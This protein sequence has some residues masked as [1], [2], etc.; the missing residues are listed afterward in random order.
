MCSWKDIEG[1]LGHYQ[2]SDSGLVRS[3][4]S[5]DSKILSPY[6]NPY[7]YLKI[8][9]WLNNKQRHHFIH[10]LVLEAFNPVEGMENLEV[11]HRNFI[12]TDNDL[13]NL[14]WVTHAQNM[15]HAEKNGAAGGYRGRTWRF[16]L[17]DGSI[18][19]STGIK[20]FCDKYGLSYASMYNVSSGRNKSHKGFSCLL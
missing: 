16:V 10:R 1:Y 9:L 19:E 12:K 14:E 13:S 2:I 3:L 20:P 5:F 18:E 11:N 6:V 15:L 17:P 7:G 8:S 4:K